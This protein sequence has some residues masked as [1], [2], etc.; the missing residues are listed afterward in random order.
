[1]KDRIKKIIV[2]NQN[3]NVKTKKRNF[4]FA[5]TNKIVTL[6]GSRRVGKSYILFNKMN[7]LKNKG[8]QDK[9]LYINFEDERLYN[10]KLEELNL[11][12]EAYFE[13]F[14]ENLNAEIYIFFD[15]IQTISNWE[16]FIRRL[17]DSKKYIIYLTGSSS[18]LLSKEIATSLRGRTLS[19]TIFPL[20][21]KEFLNFKEVK[22]D[23]NYIY[24]HKVYTIK[25]YFNE[26]LEFGGFPEILNEDLK[27]EVL[28]SYIDLIIYK[29]LIERYNIRNITILKSLLFFLLSNVSK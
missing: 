15:E 8:L 17:Y 16:L 5:N 20:S 21:F 2:E 13:L 26:Y 25:K 28:Q 19:F 12:L 24:S 27:I 11:I 22:L 29:D 1:M 6:I 14:P 23:K 7:E 10:I 9:I 4:Q 3:Q 18:K